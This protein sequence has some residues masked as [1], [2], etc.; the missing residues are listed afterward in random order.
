MGVSSRLTDAEASV[1]RWK[2]APH[3][4]GGTVSNATEDAVLHTVGCMRR[5]RFG[6]YVEME[7]IARFIT[8]PEFAVGG[9]HPT[10][11]SKQVLL[12]G[13]CVLPLLDEI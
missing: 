10:H 13:L 1:A 9:V 3:N 5:R 6:R 11:L 7:R 12:P 2:D 4:G 8:P